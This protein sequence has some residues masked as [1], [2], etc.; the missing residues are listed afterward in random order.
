MLSEMQINLVVNQIVTNYNPEK[1]LIFGSYAQDTATEISDLDLLIIKDTDLPQNKRN[2]EVR[3]LLKGVLFPIDIL[4]Y[5]PKEIELFRNEKFT[6]L[7]QALKT[8]KIV[9]D[10]NR[11]NSGMD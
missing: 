6:F 9:Y 5:T 10:I 4:V 7:Y 2:Y 1:I 3:K 8:T 11:K